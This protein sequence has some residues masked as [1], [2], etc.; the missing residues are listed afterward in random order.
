MVVAPAAVSGAAGTIGSFVAAPAVGAV[1]GVGAA[2]VAIAGTVRTVVK[3][4]AKHKEIRAAL[5]NADRIKGGD[6]K[7]QTKSDGAGQFGRKAALGDLTGRSQ[8]NVDSIKDGAQRYKNGD[9]RPLD[10]P[11]AQEA[12]EQL[13]NWHAQQ[14]WGEVAA[15]C[16]AVKSFRRDMPSGRSQPGGGAAPMGGAGGVAELRAVLFANEDTLRSTSATVAAV[17]KTIGD[18]AGDMDG[19]LKDSATGRDVSEAFSAAG[20]SIEAAVQAL[21]LALQRTADYAKGL[22]R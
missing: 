20:Q 16:D 3:V 8:D 17:G 13:I 21:D 22:D 18:K 9:P 10:D 7:L 19:E 1:I 6:R 15:Y 5:D 2:G 4:V 14:R 12:F 11:L